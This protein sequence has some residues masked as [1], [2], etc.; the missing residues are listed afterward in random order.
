VPL[1]NQILFAND[2][3]DYVFRLPTLGSHIGDFSS[4]DLDIWPLCKR[5][6][7][8]NAYGASKL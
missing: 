7:F 5:V 8:G 4:I 1:G 3:A 6:D 2:R